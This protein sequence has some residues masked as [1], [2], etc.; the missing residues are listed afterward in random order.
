MFYFGFHPHG[1]VEILED[2]NKMIRDGN[3]Q[4]KFLYYLTNF[5]EEDD[6]GINVSADSYRVNYSLEVFKASSNIYMLA[7]ELI[8]TIVF[9]PL[10]V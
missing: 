4:T 5:S 10:Y 1:D 8:F 3:I 2:W 9:L 6:L 7:V